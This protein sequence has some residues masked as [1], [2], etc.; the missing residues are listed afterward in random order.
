MAIEMSHWCLHSPIVL[1]ESYSRCKILLCVPVVSDTL[2][3][4]HTSHRFAYTSILRRRLLTNHEQGTAAMVTLEYANLQR[5]VSFVQLFLAAWLKQ[6]SACYTLSWA[7]AGRRDSCCAPRD[8]I[9]WR[10]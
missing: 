1:G 10:V 7:C 9:Y 4:I 8:A 3:P 6:Q 5:N 2:Q